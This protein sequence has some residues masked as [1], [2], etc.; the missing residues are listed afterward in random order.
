MTHKV[1]SSL[2]AVALVLALGSMAKADTITILG[3]ATTATNGECNDLTLDPS[4][5]VQGE[6]TLTLK[7]GELPGDGYGLLYVTSVPE[8]TSLLLLGSGLVGIGLKL[9]RRAIRH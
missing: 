8:P 3:Q 1:L 5:L 9:R 2:A 7:T 6:S 4:L